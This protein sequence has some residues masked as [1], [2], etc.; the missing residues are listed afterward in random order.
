MPQVKWEWSFSPQTV[1]SLANFMVIVV[2]CVGLFYKM[3]SD[4]QVAKDNMVRLEQ[5]VFAITSKQADMA[6]RT[7][8]VETKVDIILPAVQRVEQNLRMA[9]PR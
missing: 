5:M 9:A 3:Q 6:E 8:K 2:G 1:I 7:A 4:L